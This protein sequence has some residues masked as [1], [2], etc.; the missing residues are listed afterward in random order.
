MKNES[1]GIPGNG[2]E[3]I[4]VDSRKKGVEALEDRVSNFM[5]ISE[6]L[7]EVVF[8]K[9]VP[10]FQGKNRNLR[11]INYGDTQLVY[12]LEVN[13][14]NYTLLL[15]QPTSE[16]GIVKREH[17]NLRRLAKNNPENVVAPIH[18]FQSQDGKRELYVTPYIHQARCIASDD[19]EG[20][21]VYVPEPDYHFRSFSDEER[22]VINSSMIALLVKMY[23]QKNKQ[24]IAACKIGGGDFMLEKGY[25][26]EPLTDENILKRMKLI[27]ARDMVSTSLEEYIQTIRNEFSKR[28]YYRTEE[29]RDKSILV[30][31]KSRIPM[32]EEEINK[33][34]E[35]GLKLRENDKNFQRYI[36]KME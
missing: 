13:D 5:G 36:L 1:L 9:G 22:K 31:H 12:V 4:K 7:S 2:F 29:T 8:E 25:E 28:T 20:W 30:N 21:G 26:D 27:A 10:E 33:G 19:E 15:G 17:D 18:Y 32:T 34:I 35:I 16:F 11:F 14:R 6:F 24:G 23:N 3:Y